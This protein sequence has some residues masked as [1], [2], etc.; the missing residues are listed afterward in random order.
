[1]GIS[2]DAGT[3]T[4]TVTGGSFEEPYTMAILDAD[5]TV[6]GYI[7]AGGYGNREYTVSK[8]L[9]IGSDEGSTFFDLERSLIIAADGYSIEF[10][11]ENVGIAVQT[12]DADGNFIDGE[13]LR[14]RH[15][16]PQDDPYLNVPSPRF[17]YELNYRRRTGY[18]RLAHLGIQ[19]PVG[20]IAQTLPHLTEIEFQGR[21]A[22]LLFVVGGLFESPEIF[23][24]NMKQLL[25]TL[26]LVQE[27]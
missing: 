22:C 3:E 11:L 6:G 21:R 27:V 5:G 1:M 9:V 7:T 17:V 19:H 12:T 8:N 24:V 10:E 26:G 2:Y 14:P 15:R 25:K 16:E 18:R 23:S 20:F 13:A 4:I